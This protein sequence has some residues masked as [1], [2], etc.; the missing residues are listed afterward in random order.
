[1]GE[2]TLSLRPG[3]YAQ[4]RVAGGTIEGTIVPGAA[5]LKRVNNRGIEAQGVFVAA[6]DAARWIPVDLLGRQ[7][8]R[9]A[10]KG[11]LAAGDLVLVFGHQDLA[12]GARVTVATFGGE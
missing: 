6:A 5:V 11:G 10:V 7:G 3:M 12:D 4:V 1:M 2:S 8:D 9:V